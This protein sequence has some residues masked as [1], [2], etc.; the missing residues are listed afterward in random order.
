[1]KSSIQALALT[2]VATAIAAC[3]GNVKDIDR[4]QAN[5]VEKSIF[6]GVWYYMPSVVETQYNQGILFEGVQGD[7]DKVRW[8]IQENQLIAYRVYAYLQ[9]QEQSNNGAGNDF[10]GSP[11][12]AFRISSHFDV[13]REYNPATGDQN[14]VLVENTTDRPWFEREWMRVDWS[15][16]LVKDGW[17][18][19]D[20]A[21][22]LYPSTPYYTQEHEIDNPHR[23]EVTRD[24]INVVGNYSMW[25]DARVCAALQDYY[26]G[27]AE[28]K[29]KMSFMRAQKRDYEPLYYPDE[30]IVYDTNGAP[31]TD[32]DGDNDGQLDGNCQRIGVPMFERFGFFRTERLAYSNEYQWTRDGRI[33]LAN[34]W[35]I[36]EQN[37]DTAGA[38]IP[39]QTRRPRL[40][41]YY[42]NVEFPDDQEIWDAAHHLFGEWD[43]SMRKMVAIL[44]N[45]QG[46]NLN[47]QP[48]NVPTMFTVAKNGC[49][50]DA[51]KAF[52][53]AHKLTDTLSTYGIGEVTRG[54]VKRACAVLEAA[55]ADRSGDDK[56]VWQK[57]GDLRWSQLA[58]HDTPNNYGGILG[59]GP[60]FADPETGEI[61]AANAN[62]YGAYLELYATSAAD[63]VALMNGDLSVASVSSGE[64][65]RSRVQ[66]NRGFGAQANVAGAHAPAKMS[67][68]RDRTQRLESMLRQ[69]PNASSRT[70]LDS[71]RGSLTGLGHPAA[72]AYA[73]Q[74]SNA[75]LNKLVGKPLDREL[76]MND[77]ITRGL[78]DDQSSLPATSGSM[79]R[80]TM[81]TA[82]GTVLGSLGADTPAQT[83][84]LGALR[85]M[86][87]DVQE[88]HMKLAR[89]G[90][91]MEA[92]F[93][94]EGL[95][96][97]AEE[98]RGLPWEEVYK[99]TRALL[100]ES[101]AL[102]EVGHTLGLR[103]NFEGSFD[104]LNYHDEFW[105]KYD[106]V[107]ETVPRVDGAGNSTKAERFMY[108]SIMDYSARAFDDISGVG[109]YDEAAIAFGYGGLVQLWNPG[110]S[111][112]DQGDLF[113]L[114]DYTQIPKILGGGLSCTTTINCDPALLL[115]IQHFNAYQN[116]Q[117]QATRQREYELYNRGLLSY[118]KTALDGQ[119]PRVQNIKA[120]RY[121][122]F[123]KL[124]DATR[125]YYQTNDF[126][127]L[128]YDEVPFMFC[129]DDYVFDSNVTCQPYDKGASYR[130]LVAD[131]WE[132]YSQYYVFQAF[133]R[134]RAS[135][136]SRFTNL[137]RYAQTLIRS[138]FGPM[139]SVY[140]YYLYGNDG[141]GY[142]LDGQWVTLNDFP[143][144]EDWQA[145]SID[146]LNDLASVL[147]MPEPGDYCLDTVANL[148]KPRVAGDTCASGTTMTVDPGVGRYLDTTWTDEYDY[149]PTRI[150]AFWD[151]WAALSAITSNE[152]F[153]YRNFNDY[154]DS[155]AFSLSY[156]RGLS[157]ELIQLFTSAFKQDFNGVAWRYDAGAPEQSRFQPM[158][159][160]DTYQT[161]P[162]PAL[163]AVQPSTSW[164]LRYYSVVLPMARYDSMF[165][166]TE[167]FL[168]YSRVCLEGYEDCLT[169]GVAT[170]EYTDPLTSY[171][172]IAPITVTQP[173]PGQNPPQNLGA[174]AVQEA[175]QYVTDVYT[176]AKN[177]YD[178]AFGADPESPATAAAALELRRAQ[179][180]VNERSSFLD[181]VRQLSNVFAK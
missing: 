128:D 139:S 75:R 2:L 157:P 175:A 63:Q 67:A 181:I 98:M 173:S 62:V 132:R 107:T 101:I 61:I 58:W 13:R 118:L 129:P 150:G 79:T 112:F 88:A 121:I 147:M 99:R 168:N 120:R 108:S 50:V 117:D 114:Y 172:Y 146:G 111:P 59:Y 102:H 14:N 33:Y 158:P 76:L 43:L 164:T 169:F 122:T 47:I 74:R 165:D 51:A 73:T 140:R 40:L 151:K 177:A 41:T 174:L 27:K 143:L 22:W 125:R 176:P 166:Y 86:S 149:E 53:Q 71:A 85:D 35:N 18:S 119:T 30:A 90:C 123:D 144:G 44:K 38:L 54:N 110:V 24:N 159:L 116:A 96:H 171:R 148:Y 97:I 12:A 87:M 127:L 100:F 39:I 66:A 142:D 37:Y 69:G 104:A 80:D 133:K 60:S 162:S 113:Y 7:G 106:P 93:A 156:W 83:S 161:P 25:T 29:V 1:M 124:Y 92:A 10:K 65:A 84:P 52:A 167:D 153:F 11:V 72:K 21:V 34:R 9:N 89:G 103:H 105:Q 91:A 32:C 49:N 163:P 178:T 56:F 126:E 3:D 94:D 82:T 5:K 78:M 141:L 131:R 64:F 160:V 95:L 17:Q 45:Q 23:A 136:P 46:N 6:D 109:P 145:A 135:F 55:T 16:N 170:E 138:Y 4:T 19:I 15:V 155:G 180:G 57:P 70:G 130:E 26:C 154:L 134:D 42:T 8:E 31:I 20:Y 115:A 81:V 36:W 137:R 28:V 68:L 48:S 179:R 77:E 152:G